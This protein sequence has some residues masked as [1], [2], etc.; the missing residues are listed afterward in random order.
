MGKNFRIK[1]PWLNQID[2][3]FV[4]YSG[5]MKSILPFL[6]YALLSLQVTA[7][8]R[9]DDSLAKARNCLTEKA[10]LALGSWA[11]VNIGSGFIVAAQASGEAKY[12]WN[13]NA[14]WNFINLGLAGLGYLNALRATRRSFSFSDNMEAQQAI[15]KLYVFNMGLDLAYIAGGFYLRQRG[16]NQTSQDSRDRYIGYG[17]SIAVQGGY[18]LGMD[19]LMYVL[20]HRNTRVMNQRLRQL[21]FS[22]GPAG[23]SLRY[24]F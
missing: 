2:T 22:A 17:S 16:Y 6:L 13:M 15:E 3:A 12:F 10:M 18:L 1:F 19:A 7:Q 5:F 11:V 20:H 9:F 8:H 4:I 21:E 24:S 14:Y 23:L